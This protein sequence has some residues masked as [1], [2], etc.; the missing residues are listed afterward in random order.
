MRP[1][2]NRDAAAGADGHVGVTRRQVLA[3]GAA[4]GMGVPLAGGL[5]AA[6]GRSASGA[7]GS[8]SSIGIVVGLDALAGRPGGSH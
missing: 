4:L 3:R 7:H 1:H 8:G 6:C 5:L 2:S